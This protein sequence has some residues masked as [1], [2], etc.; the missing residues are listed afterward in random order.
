MRRTTNPVL[1]AKMLSSVRSY[2][3]GE[4]MTVQGTINKAFILFFVLMVSASWIWGKLLQ[5]AQVSE[6]GTGVSQVAA[7][8]MPLIIAGFIGG[9]IFA[10]LTIFKV[11]W[12]KITTPLYALCEGLVLG[13]ISVLFE[14]RYPGIV[15][16]AVGLTFLTMFCMLTA[17]RTGLVRVTHKFRMGVVA[18]TGAICLFYFLSFILGFFGI[19][20]PLIHGSGMFGIG[21]SLIVV[22]VASLNLVLDFDLID[23]LSRQGAPKNMEWYGAFALMVTLIWLYLEMLRLLSKLNSRR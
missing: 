13:G 15:M 18:A 1:S 17:Y 9:F 19:Q 8:A 12:A 16:Q 6:Y 4:Q 23:Q 14:M 20:M 7:S 2:G 5:S 22:G 10:L 11:Q 21:F 3:L